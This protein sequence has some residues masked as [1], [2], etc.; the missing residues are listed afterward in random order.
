MNREYPDATLIIC[1][2]VELMYESLCQT[3]RA[4]LRA[5]VRD[6]AKPKTTP[7]K[8]EVVERKP[9]EEAEKSSAEPEPVQLEVA[10]EVEETKPAEDRPLA[11]QVVKR[12]PIKL[13]EPTAGA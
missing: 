4:K 1:D 13:P 7:K 6:F 5:A 12:F 10:S 9:A 2:E 3:C 11:N 8:S